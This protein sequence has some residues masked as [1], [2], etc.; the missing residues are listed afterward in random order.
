MTDAREFDRFHPLSFSRLD[1][2]WA[3]DVARGVLAFAQ[4]AVSGPRV[5]EITVAA[6]LAL[7][8]RY[9]LG[10]HSLG[11]RIAHLDVDPTSMGSPVDSARL[12]S[13]LLHGLHDAPEQAPWTDESGR[14]WWGDEPDGGW[15]TIGQS[16]TLLSLP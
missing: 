14:A 1:Q 2:E 4:E 16:R 15:D 13:D 8:I 11:V 6:D 5:E 10:P 7:H 12:A 3:E 9:H